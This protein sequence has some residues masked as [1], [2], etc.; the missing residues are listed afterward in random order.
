MTVLITGDRT[1]LAPRLAGVVSRKFV[2]RLVDRA[3]FALAAIP[4]HRVPLHMPPGRAIRSD[5]H[6]EVQFAV[7]GCDPS[8]AEQ[9]RAVARIAAATKPRTTAPMITLRPLPR[10]VQLAGSAIIAGAPS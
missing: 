3:D 7:L 9:C 2:L 4:L 5:D 10:R 1:T 6:A 8:Y